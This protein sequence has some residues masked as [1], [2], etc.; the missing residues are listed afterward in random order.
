MP[1][2]VSIVDVRNILTRTSGFLREVTS[3]SLQPYRGCTFGNAL[4]GVGCYVQHSRHL[5]AGRAWGGFLEVR[6][7]AGSSY[8]GSYARER[9]YAARRD[10]PFSIFCS[11][12]TDPFVPQESQ[13]RVTRS[14]LEAMRDLPPDQLVLQTHSHRIA[15]EMELLQ[16]VA[17][18]T[19]LRV[20]VS[21]ESDRDRLPGLPPPACSVEQ[22]LEACARL[23]DAGLTTVV[24]VA[25]LLPIAEPE[26]FF[27]RLAEVADAVVIDHFIQ[28][29]GTAQGTR[30]QST[31]L[32]AAMAAI[33]P[34]SVTL[35]YRDRM[36][37]VA[38]R[39]F[40]GRVGVNVAGFAG[41][42]K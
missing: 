14:I 36:V 37:A 8:R 2:E 42:Y 5:L 29:D 30:T 19:Q 12:A 10:Q 32:P 6:A 15:G 4:C 9:R 38:Q 25:P 13:Y 16:A 27:T 35:R 1:V 17:R 23:R 11:S 26:R 28:G 34:E 22:R 21:I 33:D 39:H 20:H 31:P 41:K 24:T 7:N 3:H 18:G 40:P